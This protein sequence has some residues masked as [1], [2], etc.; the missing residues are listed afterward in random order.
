MPP[1]IYDIGIVVLSL[2]PLVVVSF[3]K[4]LAS[5]TFFVE[6]RE[7]TFYH[8]WASEPLDLYQISDAETSDTDFPPP[9]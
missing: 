7:L 8:T 2:F 5:L 4:F 1:V 6:F 3:I 9:T